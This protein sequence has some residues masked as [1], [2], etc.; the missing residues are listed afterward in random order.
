MLVPVG[1]PFMA[2]WH[3]SES[4]DAF[5]PF[6]TRTLI[7]STV[8]DYL[9]LKCMKYCASWKYCS[10]ALLAHERQGLLV[11]MLAGWYLCWHQ[12]YYRKVDYTFIGKFI[13]YWVLLS[14]IILVDIHFWMNILL[15]KI[16]TSINLQH[17]PFH[18][19]P[20]LFYFFNAYH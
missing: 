8:A 18:I 16:L 7:A 6:S 20:P 9:I 1:L 10:W 17:L 19:T 12:G 3:S 13:L 15:S 5:S 2:E 11:V 4:L 14:S